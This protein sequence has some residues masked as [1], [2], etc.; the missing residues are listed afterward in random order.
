MGDTA[1]PDARTTLQPGALLAGRY[2]LGELLD[3]G[4]A[5]Q[6][7]LAADRHLESEPVCCKVLLPEWA[8]HPSAVNDLK[9]EV[10]I[11]RRLRHQ[12]IRQ[13][14]TFWDTDGLYFITMEYVCGT[15][16]AHAL[17]VRRQP[18]APA[19]A[20]AWAL[21]LAGA[22]DYAHGEGVLHRDIKPGNV[23]LSE[24]GQVSLAD[25]GI[26]ET[27]SGHARGSAQAC[28]TPRYMSP[29]QIRG[30]HIGARSD[31]YSL[32]STLYELLAG[33]PPFYEGPIV[34][35]IQLSPA[36]PLRHYGP[37]V[38]SVFE[39]ALRKTPAERFPTCSAFAQALADAAAA[40]PVP[41]VGT[42]ADWSN[43]ATEEVHTVVLPEPEGA[44]ARSRLGCL[45]VD[46]GLL[47][48]DE[49][50]Q[51]LEA[52]RHAPRER[53]GKVLVRLGMVTERQIARTLARQL[54]LEYI[55][56]VSLDPDTA[57]APASR[58]AQAEAGCLLLR[59]NHDQLL[60]AMTDPL[61]IDLVNA[62]E[63]EY[64]AHASIVVCTES[65][66]QAALQ[67]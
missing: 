38:E 36:P 12:H 60:I 61:R 25:F 32:A 67:A 3:T 20:A 66:L 28:G 63:A 18:F 44:A 50:N 6:V 7:W 5:G 24:R 14:Y 34:E 27:L 31:Q 16:L 62:L 33:H 58:A 43:P 13:V 47:T 64:R 30:Q 8:R 59:R 11:T 52:Q 56:E 4:G 35:Q 40:C 48:D 21:Q 55:E 54:R 37:A 29:E 39:Q 22:L 45:L 65:A 10:I 26:A 57:C 2:E 9:R 49:L 51:G 42:A 41:D 46:A 1:L 53:L 19:Q 15:T 17:G 23:L